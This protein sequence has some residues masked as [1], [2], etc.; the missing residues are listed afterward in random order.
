MKIDV[1]G[2]FLKRRIEA[3]TELVPEDLRIERGEFESLVRQ[4]GISK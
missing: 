1:A 3:G 2:L 4:L